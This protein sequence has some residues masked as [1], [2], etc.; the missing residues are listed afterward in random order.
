MSQE[1]ADFRKYLLRPELKALLREAKVNLR[2]HALVLVMYEAALRAS[3][4][5]FLTLESAR[6]LHEFRIYVRRGK[7]SRDGWVELSPT[8]TR[9]LSDWIAYCYPDA[10][11]R[12]S[13]AWVFPPLRKYGRVGS[14]GLTRWGV[15]GIIRSLAE[16]AGLP[17]YLRHPHVLKHTRVMD[18]YDAARKGGGHP[19]DIL[20]GVAKLVGHRTAQTTLAY[21]LSETE[22]Q[23]EI[24]RKATREAVAE[25]EG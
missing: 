24:I 2:D 6:S 19:Q 9:A 12:K 5:S 3:E 18:L 16:R 15:Y 8:C 13:K 4:P 10:T 22:E 20:A 21:Y 7:G 11:R 1:S 25:E 23:R 14:T 17:T